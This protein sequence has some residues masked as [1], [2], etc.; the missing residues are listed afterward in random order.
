MTEK[1]YELTGLTR[2]VDGVTVHRIR[3]LRSFRG[4]VVR[5]GALGGWVQCEGNLGHSGNSWVGGE[6]VVMEDALVTGN[7]LVSVRALVRGHAY[8][9]GDTEVL[10][11]V[12]V[13]ED[14][15]I[16]D[17]ACVSG[18]AR[19]LGDACVG[20]DATVR[21]EAVIKGYVTVN[22]ISSISANA[23]LDSEKRIYVSNANV[24]RD[25][26]VNAP[27]H[28]IVIFGMF[29]DVVTV[30]RAA[31]RL[32]GHVVVAGCQTF[33]LTQG[34]DFLTRL[35]DKHNWDLPPGWTHLRAA[36]LDVVRAW[37]KPEVSQHA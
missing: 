5:K 1:K 14:A 7:A 26:T 16:S 2:E 3:A 24:G 9:R 30:Y 37:G 25:A 29:P 20:N 35:A 10:G 34:E 36:L 11:D 18:R 33:P 23:V 6:A 19:V 31:G 4:G 8:V 32:D 21:N 12:S 17:N 22:G 28:V 13:S 15:E 27:G